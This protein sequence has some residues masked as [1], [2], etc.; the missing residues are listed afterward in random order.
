M[1][2]YV[3]IAGNAILIGMYG[4]TLARMQKGSK[5]KLF[6]TIIILLI[7]ACVSSIVNSFSNSVLIR[8]DVNSETSGILFWAT[9]QALAD[10]GFEGCFGCAHWL[11]AFEY[12]SIAKIMPLALKGLE[13]SDEQKNY[14]RMISIGLLVVNAAL[15][16]MNGILE[17]LASYYSWIGKDDDTFVW[18]QFVT[19]LLLTGV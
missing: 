19:Y 8:K 16:I 6:I 9:I 15:A 13:M 2:S 1:T 12:Y 17:W 3:I 4:V 5:Y 18:I 14:D 10:I 7:V 11:F